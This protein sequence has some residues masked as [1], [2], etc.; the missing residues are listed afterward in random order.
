MSWLRHRQQLLFTAAVDAI[1]IVISVP[2][3]SEARHGEQLNSATQ[4]IGLICSYLILGWLFGSYSLLRWPKLKW[5]QL[6]Q[7]VGLSAL[8]T[9]AL[10]LTLG[11]LSKTTPLQLPLLQRGNIGPLMLSTAFASVLFRALL[12]KLQ[13]QRSSTYQIL[14]DQSEKNQVETEWL[15]NNRQAPNITTF[16]LSAISLTAPGE[17]LAIS[18]IIQKTKDLE[19]IFQKALVQKTRLLS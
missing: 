7:R 13:T 2:L 11:W 19:P 1:F 6:V 8:A 18:P 3:I 17:L 12:H 15:H 16:D 10:A 9:L 14:V 5:N 4:T